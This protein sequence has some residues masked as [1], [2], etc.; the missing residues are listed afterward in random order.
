MS[1]EVVDYK[2]AGKRI[3]VLRIQKGLSQEELSSRADVSIPYLSNIE[4]AHS[5]AALPTFIKIA[6]A[7]NVT[8]NDLLYDC[9][10]NSRPAL[11]ST[12]ATVPEDC[13]DYEMRVLVR[14]LDGMKSALRA[15]EAYRSRVKQND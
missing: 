15:G 3:K 8:L 5:K 1:N 14:A 12:I 13:T 2:A 11:E 4:N 7:L 6:N 9:Q 10:P